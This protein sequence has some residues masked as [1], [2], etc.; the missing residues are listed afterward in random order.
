MSISIGR[1]GYLGI[2]L[3]STPGDVVA[4]TAFLPYTDISLRAHHEPLE[5]IGSKASRLMDRGSVVGKKW[6]EGDIEIDLDTHNSGYLFK[7]ALGNEVLSTGTPNTHTFYVTASGNTPKTATMIF[8]RDTD[9]EQYAFASIDELTM[10]VSDGLAKL[11]ASVQAKYATV[12]ASQNVTVTSGTVL[13]FKD[14]NVYFGSDLTTAIAGSATAVNDLSLTI[15]NNLE[16]IHRSGSEQVSTIRSKGA[17]VSGKYTLYFDSETDKNAYYNL[18]KRAMYVRFTGNNN[19]QINMRIPRFRLSEGE[20]ETGIDDFFVI[21]C[22]F[23][24]ED[25]VD[26]GTGTRLFDVQILNDRGT[27]YA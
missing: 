5:V 4:S 21:N 8:G 3:E 11:T 9:I 22:E 27:V 24:A 26:S 14:M 18:N 23:V 2:G 6:S 12:G 7:M 13:S 19:E 25:V 10:E 15:A 1:L 16:V 17:R 20:I